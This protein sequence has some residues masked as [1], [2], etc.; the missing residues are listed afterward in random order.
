MGGRTLTIEMQVD[1]NPC[2]EKIQEKIRDGVKDLLGHPHLAS[3]R[4]RTSQCSPSWLKSSGNSLNRATNQDLTELFR[5]VKS[6]SVSVSE[7]VPNRSSA[8]T[9]SMRSIFC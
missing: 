1:Y 3:G 8:R 9:A 4:A 2:L 6:L 5:T 7:T